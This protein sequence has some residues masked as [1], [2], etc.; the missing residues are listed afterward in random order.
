[1]DL[2]SSLQHLQDKCQVL[3][4]LKSNYEQTGKCITHQTKKTELQI[5]KEFEKLHQFLQDEEASRLAA[6]RQEEEEKS[7]T[8]KQNIEEINIWILYLYY[9]LK[10]A[11]DEMGSESLTFMQSLRALAKGRA[12]RFFQEPQMIP[13]SLINEAKHL[14]NLTFRVWQNMLEIVQY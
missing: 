13:E 3:K 5:K 6:L 8:M 1:T 12:Q 14:G 11:K 7:V 9:I 4:K 2:K 10:M